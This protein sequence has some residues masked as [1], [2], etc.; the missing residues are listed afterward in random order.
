MSTILKAL[1][2]LEQERARAK[3]AERPLREEVVL[4]RARRR[5]AWG[6]W[7]AAG[8]ALA[9]G[10]V[11][12]WA[13]L[14]RFDE[15]A[16]APGSDSTSP[17]AV[18][19]APPAPVGGASH[20]PAP[21]APPASVAAAPP[22][23]L[24]A[25]PRAAAPPAATVPS[26]PAPASPAELPPAAPRTVTVAPGASAA[27]PRAPAEPPARFAPRPFDAPASAAP[28]PDRVASATSPLAPVRE[29]A[30]SVDPDPPLLTRPITGRAPRVVDEPAPSAREELPVSVVRTSW[31]PRPDRRTAWVAIGSEAPREVREGEWVGAYEVRAIEPDGVLFADGPLLVHE[32]V[33][34]R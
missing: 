18:A 6:A 28:T 13:A 21:A 23:S 25:A 31:H 1:R 33:G 27:V 26:T 32:P 24:A 17:A 9:I 4:A 14:T 7:A 5:G 16:V 34:A 20:A 30:P 10:F 8:V 3:G 19:A 12:T 2:R 29:A 22:G 11:A 15:G